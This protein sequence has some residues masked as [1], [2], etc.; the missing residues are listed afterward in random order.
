MS[1]P[2]RVA[3]FGGSG[4]LGRGLATRL[5]DRGDRPLVISR[6]DPGL[7][8]VDFAAW[9]GRALGDWAE[10][11]GDVTHVVHLA[12]KRV[13]CAPTQANLEE[14]I[15]SREGTVRL[16]GEAL[17]QVGATPQ[18]WV[19]LSSL[20]RHGDV[21]EGTV[22]ARSRLPLDGIPQHV[23]VCRRWEAAYRDVTVDVPR[24][25]LLR[26]GIAIGGPDDPATAQLIRLARFGLGGPVAGGRQWVSWI[27]ADDLFAILLRAIDDPTME[28]A[29]SATAPTP[30]TN[31]EL[32]AGYRRAVGRRFGLP[33][34]AW[35]T[36]I[37]A[38]LLGS[39]PNL[40]L[41]GR[42]GVPTRLL[43]EGFTFAVTELDDAIRA[44]VADAGIVRA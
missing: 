43:E 18:V 19:Q 3:L 13:D 20:A 32:M 6:R 23:E 14:L 12:G 8:R 2:K 15:S 44:A 24:R 25:V 22:D 42:A 7:P 4:F 30:V 35:I 37:G 1:D 38:R 16:A 26:P 39:D 40:V 31:R 17:A 27:A 34:P 9:D 5:A 11:L 41:S 36:R 10:Q 28:G 21:A 29:Y 33:S